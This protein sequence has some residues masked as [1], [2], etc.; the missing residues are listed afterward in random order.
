METMNNIPTTPQ[1]DIIDLDLSV[2]KKKKFRINGDDSRV[3]E[4]NTSDMNIITRISD[5]LPKLRELEDDAKKGSASDTTLEE[6]GELMRSIDTRMRA[7]VDEIFNAP[8]SSVCANDGSMYDSFN[9]IPRYEHIITMLMNQYENNL[10][11]EYEKAKNV[12]N[13]HTGKYGK[14]Q[15]DWSTT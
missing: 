3:L 1:T 4:L 9:G 12:L 7:Y 5:V 11:S 2:T 15:E 10:K 14:L 6:V 8:V 13:K